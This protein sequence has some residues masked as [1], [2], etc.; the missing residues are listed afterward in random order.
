MDRR[1]ALTRIIAGTVALAALLAAGRIIEGHAIL[2]ESSPAANA[3]VEG[4]DVAITLKYNSRVDSTRSKVQLSHPDNSVSD[5]P[6]AKQVSPDTLSSKATG[7]TP[8]AYKLQWQ[9]LAPDGHITRGVV[10]FT[11]KGS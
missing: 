3:T 4:P 11:V 2:K 1:F 7:L 8:G 5:L 9:V 6:L 10:P